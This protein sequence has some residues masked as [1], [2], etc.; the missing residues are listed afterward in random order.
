MLLVR[1][2]RQWTPTVIF[3]EVSD[4]IGVSP[5]AI[6]RPAA[7]RMAPSPAF[8]APWFWRAFWLSGTAPRA[9]AS[10]AATAPSGV[11]VL[12]ASAASAACDR[13]GTGAT[14]PITTRAPCTV[15]PLIVNSTV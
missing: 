15:D 12:P 8:W 9:A 2:L 14:A 7:R 4:S 13:H 5:H 6:D 11:I 3:G 10:A 1:N